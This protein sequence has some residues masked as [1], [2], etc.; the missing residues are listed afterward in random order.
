VTDNE[1]EPLG[2]I[3]VGLSDNCIE[4]GAGVTLSSD[5]ALFAVYDPPDHVRVQDDR[6]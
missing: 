3:V 6:T 5:E 1:T 4:E 2:L